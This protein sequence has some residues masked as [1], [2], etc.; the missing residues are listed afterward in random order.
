MAKLADIREK[1]P[2][3]KEAPPMV[4]QE[5]P[6]THKATK[7]VLAICTR[8]GSDVPYLCKQHEVGKF[9]DVKGADGTITRKRDRSA[10]KDLIFKATAEVLDIAL[11]VDLGLI[12]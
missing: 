2:T 4:V 7:R 3:A 11:A 10:G 5:G 6:L 1:A 8:A 9:A 12:E